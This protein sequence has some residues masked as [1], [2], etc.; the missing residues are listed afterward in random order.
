ALAA[1]AM[2][3]IFICLLFIQK[4]SRGN[5]AAALAAAAGVVLCNATGFSGPAI[6]V[7]A[8]LGI[9]VAVLVEG[10]R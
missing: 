8:L 10:S 3:S 1:F 5:V 2:T 9:A 4:R 6:L 7:G